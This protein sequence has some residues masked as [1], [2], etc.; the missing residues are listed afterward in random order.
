ML[1]RIRI[2]QGKELGGSTAH[3]GM[4]VIRGNYR[5]YDKWAQLTDDPSWSY[6]SLLPYF[7]KI[8]K[9]HGSFPKCMDLFQNP[10]NFH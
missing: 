8:E 5:D 1:Q 7:T 3:N 4:I 6:D 2:G 10:Y 9:Y